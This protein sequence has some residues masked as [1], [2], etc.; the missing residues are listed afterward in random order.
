MEKGG[1]RKADFYANFDGHKLIFS[2]TEPSERSSRAKAVLPLFSTSTLRAGSDMIYKCVDRMVKR[3]RGEAKSGRPVNILNLTRSLATNA[4]TAYLFG[5]N[6]GGL[7]E[8]DEEMN[9]NGM[10]D[11]CVAVGR[12]FYLPNLVFRWLEWSS[13][14]FFPDHE[15]DA[16]IKK[17]DSF[18][19]AMVDRSLTDEKLE[20]N[21]AARLME[22]GFPTREARAQCK[23]LIFA[24]TDSTG[25]NLVTICFTLAKHPE[26]YESL[27]KRRF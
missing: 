11:A 22:Y 1:F 21:Y 25:M 5:E 15:T 14:K 3:M 13:E 27:K 8:T 12:F 7:E 26:K 24:I 2:Q 17:V 20:G 10:V 9:A 23:N 19:P 16:S 18:V 6:Y 4:V